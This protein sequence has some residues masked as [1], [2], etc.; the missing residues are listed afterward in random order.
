MN[1]VENKREI[2]AKGKWMTMKEIHYVD[3]KNT[4]RVSIFKG[5]IASYTYYRDL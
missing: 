3:P 5:A 4:A 2:I 1:F